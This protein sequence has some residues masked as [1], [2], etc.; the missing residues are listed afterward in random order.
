MF[1]MSPGSGRWPRPWRAWE[2]RPCAGLA[3]DATKKPNFPRNTS[4]RAP[5]LTPERDAW[6]ASIVE[7]KCFES[8]C[9]V[10]A[11]GIASDH[12][13]AAVRLGAAVA[14]SELAR[15]MKGASSRL[16]NLSQ[17]PRL[18]WQDGYWAESVRPEDLRRLCDYIDNQRQ[19]HRAGPLA[20]RWMQG[21]DLDE[22]AQEV[23]FPRSWRGV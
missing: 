13:H 16:W 15:Q 21:F 3:R 23:G 22:P 7:R 12:V 9:Q 10:F 4:H 6:L 8:G 2:A 5:V 17:S 1:E 11:V 18:S 20:E 19:H 14:L